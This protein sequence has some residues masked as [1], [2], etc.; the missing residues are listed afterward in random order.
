MR[1]AM[2]R[3]PVEDTR[4]I[5]LA[6]ADVLMADENAGDAIPQLE[7]VMSDA[8]PMQAQA[9]AKLVTAQIA[10][11]QPVEPATADAIL[12]MIAEHEG[13]PLQEDLIAAYGLALAGSQQFTAAVAFSQTGHALDPAFW[14]LLAEQGT[15]DD[16]LLLAIFP[17]ETKVP[18][19]A[20]QRIADRLEG[21]GFPVE[22]ATWRN[23]LSADQNDTLANDVE[24]DSLPSERASSQTAETQITDSDA[25]GDDTSARTARWDQN[26]SV[27][28][29]QQDSTWGQLA[30]GLTG[31]QTAPRETSLA[32]ATES[33]SRSAEARTL[34]E[35][36]ISETSAGPASP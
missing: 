10:A 2:G 24:I 12:A 35:Q 19:P 22:A 30:L 29:Q 14:A 8:G 26:W 5:A 11:G 33:L 7:E 3:G 28:A 1:D 25:I 21:L 15:D 32:S 20:A 9:L 34:I 27:V 31:E 23:N 17:P 36:L 4:A 16:L 6:T 13:H 18:A